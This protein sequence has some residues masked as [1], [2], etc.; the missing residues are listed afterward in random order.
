MSNDRRPYSLGTGV[1][2]WHAGERRTDRYGT[3]FLMP[4]GCNSRG[5]G[6]PPSLVRFNPAL[7]ATCGQIAARVMETRDSTHVGDWALGVFPSR[8]EVGELVALGEG[9]L[10]FEER[11]EGGHAVG[12][13]PALAGGREHHWMEPAALYRVHEQTVELLFYA[14]PER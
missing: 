9:T 14:D 5:L 12:V 11:P 1:L 13:R 7:A 2:T 6:I 8:P 3:V 4:A 10:F